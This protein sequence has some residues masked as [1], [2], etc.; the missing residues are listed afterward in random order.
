MDGGFECWVT[1][2]DRI[3]YVMHYIVIEKR[4]SVTRLLG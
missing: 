3:F 4:G 2:K 1:S